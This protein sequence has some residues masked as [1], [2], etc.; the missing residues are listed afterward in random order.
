[1]PFFCGYFSG[2]RIVFL[3]RILFALPSGIIIQLPKKVHVF[4]A[5]YHYYLFRG[6]TI[7]FVQQI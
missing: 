6:F 4:Y 3:T 2:N 7:S 1:M 5:N